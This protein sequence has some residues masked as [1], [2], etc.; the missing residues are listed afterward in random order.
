MAHPY[1]HALSSVKRF[2]GGVDD[3][4]ELNHW[5]DATKAHVADARHRLLR[6]HSFGIFLAEQKF[7]TTLLTSSGRTVPVRPVAEQHVQEDFSFIPS[8]SQCF[9]ELEIQPWMLANY[10]EDAP[11]LHAKHS[12]EKFGG[13]SEDYLAIHGFLE[14]SRLHLSDP[15][16]RVLLH[17]TL[18]VQTAEEVFGFELVTHDGTVPTRLIAE[19]HIRLDLGFIPTVEEALDTLPLEPWMY[20]GAQGVTRKLGRKVPAKTFID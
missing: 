19:E 13:T 17:T 1:H 12:S 16:Y 5:F 2:G 7:G 14:S 9:T 8:V 11:T 6:H 15:R 10:N 20:R 18:G 4:L 3:Y